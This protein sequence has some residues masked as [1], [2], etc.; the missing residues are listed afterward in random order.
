M[1]VSEAAFVHLA[2]SALISV[3]YKYL[4]VQTLN[5]RNTS[6]FS[7]LKMWMCFLVLF[8]MCFMYACH[9]ARMH[10]VGFIVVERDEVATEIYDTGKPWL[11]VAVGTFCISK[12]QWATG[13]HTHVASLVFLMEYT[14]QSPSGLLQSGALVLSWAGWIGPLFSLSS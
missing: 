13:G 12:A 1:M 11:Y 9:S 2:E 8:H 6:T 5:T 7:F 14:R 10:F 4:I 3:S